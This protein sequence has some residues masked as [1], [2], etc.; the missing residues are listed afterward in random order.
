MWKIFA[1]ALPAS[2]YLF[3]A[4]GGVISGDSL[5]DYAA[6]GGPALV[7]T[8]W[9][10]RDSRSWSFWPGDQ[11]AVFLWL[12]WPVAFPH[13]FLKSRG[14]AG[15]KPCVAI[16]AM[17]AAPWVSSWLGAYFYYDLPVWG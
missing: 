12:A 17:L 15:L 9:A 6:G 11:Y 1:I 4:S 16:L 3:C 14:Q 10:R 2:I 5:A 8:F 13:Y 7:A